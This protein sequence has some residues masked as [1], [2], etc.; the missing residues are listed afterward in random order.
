MGCWCE[1]T[2]PATE[3]P[4]FSLTRASPY[5]RKRLETLE[6]LQKLLEALP[7]DSAL[8]QAVDALLETVIDEWK[9]KGRL[10]LSIEAVLFACADRSDP[11]WETL[12]TT[13][14]EMG[15]TLAVMARK[16]LDEL[17]GVKR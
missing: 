13:Y 12:G 6:Q 7:K 17:A 1:S 14:R 5:W 10:G 2:F 15:A 9:E 3:W 8:K 4:S 16:Q 11:A